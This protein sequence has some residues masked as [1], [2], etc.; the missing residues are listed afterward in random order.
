MPF[1]GDIHCECLVL[2]EIHGHPSIPYIDVSKH[3]C[4]FCAEYIQAYNGVMQRKIN[5]L[6][7]HGHD[8]S[9][10]LPALAGVPEDINDEI[11]D[12]F[13]QRMRLLIVRGWNLLRQGGPDS[14]STDASDVKRDRYDGI[15]SLH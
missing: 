4:A 2:G 1:E 9:W 8:V 7:S 5:T 6:G 11:R 15:H 3:S 10:R 12:E 13:C 14:Q